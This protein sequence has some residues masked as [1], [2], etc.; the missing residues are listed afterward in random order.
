MELF[1]LLLPDLALL[2]FGLEGGPGRISN[3]PFE[4]FLVLFVIESWLV[5]AI[6]LEGSIATADQGRLD[7]DCDVLV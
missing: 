4:L 5:T 3:F 6:V 7:S 2:F 1:F